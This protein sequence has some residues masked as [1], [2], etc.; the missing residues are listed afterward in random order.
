MECATNLSSVSTTARHDH[1]RFS[2]ASVLWTVRALECVSSPRILSLQISFRLLDQGAIAH[3]ANALNIATALHCGFLSLPPI[4]LKV[5]GPVCV[6]VGE[7]RIGTVLVPTTRYELPLARLMAILPTVTAGPPAASVSPPTTIAELAATVIGRFPGPLMTVK[8]AGVAPR[9]D[10]GGIVMPPAAV[11]GN[12]TV[13]PGGAPGGEDICSSLDLRVWGPWTGGTV[14]LS[15]TGGSLS[16]GGAEGPSALFGF[17]SCAS[18]NWVDV[19][20]KAVAFIKVY[21]ATCTS[22]VVTADVL[23]SVIVMEVKD[24]ETVSVMIMVM[25]VEGTVTVEAVIVVSQETCRFRGV[26]VPVTV[27]DGA[28][29]ALDEPD[30]VIT[31]VV[32]DLEV[33]VTV[34][35]E[36]LVEK[37]VLVEV[38]VSV[39]VKK[40]VKAGM[41]LVEV[42]VAVPSVM[43]GVTV[44][45]SAVG[46]EL[47]VELELAGVANSSALRFEHLLSSSRATLLTNKK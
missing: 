24:S 20:T 9:E 42:T 22:D 8:A 5:G 29:A 44:H 21:G 45:V 13:L 38:T 10:P 47:V 17:C 4:P 23:V 30:R 7:A 39:S 43:V 35:V 41:L 28:G 25:V 11:P 27:V 14:G 33:I 19:S 1:L 3:T 2:P 15:L 26:V 46:V 18:T 37:K 36:V 31:V 6:V 34:V 16:A 12:G 32:V 40:M